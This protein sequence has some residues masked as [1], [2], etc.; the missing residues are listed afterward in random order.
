MISG[1]KDKRKRMFDEASIAEKKKCVDLLSMI[2][3]Q[4]G[5]SMLS[6]GNFTYICIHLYNFFCI[7]EDRNYQRRYNT[8]YTILI[9]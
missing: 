6:E 4:W 3:L 1:S 8:I 5:S 2:D 7:L 9:N